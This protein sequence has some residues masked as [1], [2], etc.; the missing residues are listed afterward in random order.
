MVAADDALSVVILKQRC[1][2]P[3]TVV[4]RCDRRVE[5]GCDPHSR[6]DYL[7]NGMRLVVS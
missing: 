6:R 2:R 3:L 4:R 5:V 7:S 1:G